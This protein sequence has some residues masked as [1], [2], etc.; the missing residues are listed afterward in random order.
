MTITATSTLDAALTYICRGWCPVPVPYRKKG[1]EI[2]GWPNLRISEKAPRYFNGA[3]QNIGVLLG[4]C[5]GNLCDVDLD[6][7]EAIAAA[8]LLPKTITFG[9]ASTPAARRLYVCRKPASKKPVIVF[10]DP[11]QTAD[12][13]AAMLLELRLGA[14]DKGTQTVFPPSVHECGEAIAWDAG[15]DERLPAV[16]DGADLV[17]HC[18]RVA[19]AALLIRYWPAKGNRPELSLALGGVLARVGWDVASIE[20]FVA[21]VAHAATIRGPRIVAVR[22]PPRTSPPRNR[23]L[24]IPS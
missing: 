12:A 13:K 9:R 2:S 5:S 21:V 23:R 8:V 14:D 4:P 15:D 17:S 20:T 3:R 16:L 18:G 19:A 6:S 7:D 11:M 1:P 22:M 10:K 24:A